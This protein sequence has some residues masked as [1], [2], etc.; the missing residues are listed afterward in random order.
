MIM[1]A[2]FMP[3]LLKKRIFVLKVLKSWI[4]FRHH[5]APETHVFTKFIEGLNAPKKSYHCLQK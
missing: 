3:T 4:S 1:A 2:S 5:K